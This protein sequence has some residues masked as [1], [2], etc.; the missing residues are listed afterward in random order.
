MTVKKINILIIDDH[1]LFRKGMISILQDSGI[2]QNIFEAGDLK[3]AEEIINNE[4]ID[5]VTLDINLPE[6]DGINFLNKHVKRKFKI[7]VITTFNSSFLVN[8][9]LRKS[10]D[11]YIKKENL[12]EN[13]IEA[14]ECTISGG[15]YVDG[16][17]CHKED[18]LTLDQKA[19]RYFCLTQ[20][21]KEVFKLLAQGKNSKEIAT[22]LG[23]SYKTVEN[24]R[25]SIM[26]KMSINSELEL[27]K[28]AIRLNLTNL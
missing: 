16:N 26:A 14:I 24:Q 18:V 3:S 20:S 15:I 25:C 10:A 4:N 8:E 1:P 22:I 21:E 19:S 11:G 5:L 12:Y 9:V 2:I 13:L 23:K 17:S 27:F 6:E 7:L 28:L